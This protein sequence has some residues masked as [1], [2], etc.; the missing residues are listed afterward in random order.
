MV[1]PVMWAGAGGGHQE[2]SEPRSGHNAP[3]GGHPPAARFI[4]K[5]KTK[6]PLKINSC[7][8]APRVHARLLQHLRGSPQADRHV[9]GFV[10]LRPGWAFG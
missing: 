6:E 4:F 1:V 7:W 8:A 10:S 9:D 5:G 3:T 2:P